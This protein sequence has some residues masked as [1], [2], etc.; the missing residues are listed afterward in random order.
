MLA[1]N[2]RRY[3]SSRQLN[4]SDGIEFHKILLV[5]FAFSKAV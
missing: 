1:D 5:S 4:A 2:S 3:F